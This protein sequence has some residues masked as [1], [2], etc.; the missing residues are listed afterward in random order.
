MEQN[1]PIHEIKAGKIR[2]AIW[3]NK[4][5]E[6]GVWFNSVVTRLYKTDDRW[7]ETRSLGHS[8]L[9]MAMKAIDMAHDWICRK[10]RQLEKAGKNATKRALAKAG[11][12]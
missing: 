5:E 3:A 4:T 9:P 10:Q 12:S 1:K 6:H 11:R 2:V 8:D 7:R